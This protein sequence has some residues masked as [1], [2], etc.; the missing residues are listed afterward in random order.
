M[1]FF[2]TIEQHNPKRNTQ[3]NTTEKTQIEI[4]NAGLSLP[5]ALDPLTVPEMS[6]SISDT[7]KAKMLLCC[8]YRARTAAEIWRDHPFLASRH[9]AIRQLTLD[10]ALSQ[11][12]HYDQ[13]HQDSIVKRVKQELGPLFLV[14][15]FK[16]N[17]L[18]QIVPPF[19]Y[20]HE[21]WP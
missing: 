11:P 14:A 18:E 16:R 19:E 4:M 20:S 15:I 10:P 12:D 1:H 3:T 7:E 8:G 17:P 6:C 21:V 13:A 2:K 5:G 9:I